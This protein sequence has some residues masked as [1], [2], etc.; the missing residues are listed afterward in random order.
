MRRK[1]EPESEKDRSDRLERTAERRFQEEAAED[2]S[3][4]AAVRQSIDR[5]GA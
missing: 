5:H 3:M 2:D 1:R 4:D